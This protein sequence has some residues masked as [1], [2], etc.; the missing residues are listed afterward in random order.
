MA[1]LLDDGFEKVTRIAKA[2]RPLLETVE[3]EP[4]LNKPVLSAAKR[5]SGKVELALAPT[6][7]PPPPPE[8]AAPKAVAPAVALG[9]A[10]TEW[11]IQVGAFRQFAL[12]QAAVGRASS[13]APALLEDAIVHILPVQSR[14]GALFR[15]RLTG[16]DKRTASKACTLLMA[17]RMDCL[18]VPPP[19]GTE[20]ASAT[21]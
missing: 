9:V 16:F 18:A 15:A 20:V 11:S 10:V 13:L 14:T 6:K 2:A 12:A 1:G 21:Q 19:Q 3:F 5:P 4:P 17:K 7:P 8:T